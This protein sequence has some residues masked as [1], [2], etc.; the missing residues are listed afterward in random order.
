MKR[1]GRP[2]VRTPARAKIICDGLA[3]G[4]PFVHACAVAGITFQTFNVWRNRDEKF[5]AQIDESIAK[6]VD[7][8]LKK[9][10]DA[11]DA[12]DWRAS[13]WLLEHCQAEHFS[14]TR[15][16]VEAV[17]SLEH[18]FIIPRETLDQIAEARAR[19]EQKQLEGNG[20]A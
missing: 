18:S 11:S 1:L 2:T 19:H 17:G 13:A 20:A 9:I 15:I 8:R 16:Q 5:R 3:R 6:G 10:E 14:K 12:G 7:R 4:L